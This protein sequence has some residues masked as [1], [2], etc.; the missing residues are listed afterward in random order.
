MQPLIEELTCTLNRLHEIIDRPVF[1]STCREYWDEIG[2]NVL[3]FLE[4]RKEFVHGTKVQQF[5][6]LFNDQ[7]AHLHHICNNC[8]V[9]MLMSFKIAQEENHLYNVTVDEPLQLGGIAEVPPVVILNTTNAN[10]AGAT[11]ETTSNVVFDACDAKATDSGVMQ[12]K[13]TTYQACPLT[14][15]K[16]VASHTLLL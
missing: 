6:F 9:T 15:K 3:R 11:Y 8:S 16:V 2:Q 1:I 7:M 13:L 4:D 14:Y 10:N 5:L 12:H